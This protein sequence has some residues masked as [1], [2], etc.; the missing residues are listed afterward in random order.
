MKRFLLAA[1]AALLIVPGVIAGKK[2]AEKPQTDRE[3]WA[4]QA[5]QMAKPVLSNLA[6]GTLRLNMPVEQFDGAGREQYAHLEA[7]GRLLCGLAPWFEVPDDSIPSAEAAM[8][9]ELLAWAH[10]GLRNAVDNTSP[11]YLNF[12]SYGQPLVDAAF[13]AQAFLRSPERLWGGLDS[14]TQRRMIVEMK[15]TRNTRPSYN[16]WL[17]FSATVEAF[18]RIA[19]E[20]P[21]LMRTDYAFRQLDDWYVGDGQY[22]DG[23]RYHNDYY[24]SFVIQPML[25]DAGRVMNRYYKGDAPYSDAKYAQILRRAARYAEVLERSISPE[26]TFPVVGRSILYRTGCLQSLAQASLLKMLPKGLSEGQVRAALTAVMRRM[27][28]APGT[29]EADGWLSMGFCGTQKNTAESY[30]CTGSMYQASTIFLPLG[31]S[32]GDSFWTAPGEDWT[33]KKAWG[34]MPF[35]GDHSIGD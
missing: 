22:G 27:L 15:A 14:L 31:L 3:Y 33:T 9:Y 11:D 12:R 35:P 28:D 34:G 16:N 7:V 8:R 32:A 5:Y 17:M 1:L 4:A 13:L 26:G 6:A 10:A 23:P 20:K 19:G 21:D 24:N 29:Y 2:R 30:L 25:V 18:L